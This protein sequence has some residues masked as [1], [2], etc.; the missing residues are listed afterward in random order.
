MRAAII[1]A[2]RKVAQS[3]GVVEMTLT[4]VAREASVAATDIYAFFTSK[5]DLLQAVVADDLATLA[6]TMRRN[7]ESSPNPADS[8][9]DPNDTQVQPLATESIGAADEPAIQKNQP[10]DTQVPSMKAAET[11]HNDHPDMPEMAARPSVQNAPETGAPTPVQ[12]MPRRFPVVQARRDASRSVAADANSNT[13]TAEA[14]ARLEEAV[15]KLQATPVDQWLERRLREFERTLYGLQHNQNQRASGHGFEHALQSLRESL[16]AV[17]MRHVMAGDESARTTS[18]RFD[19]FDKRLR[20]MLSELQ[21]ESVHL[22]KRITALENLAFATQLEHVPPVEAFAPV[23]PPEPAVEPAH[24]A[25]ETLHD[26]AP[27]S[28]APDRNEAPP[29]FLSA[30]RRSAA[31]AAAQQANED[32]RQRPPAPKTNRTMLYATC[33]L[34]ALF[35]VLLFGLNFMFRDASMGAPVARA[36]SRPAPARVVRTVAAARPVQHVA[37]KAPQTNLLKLA[38]TGDTSAELLVGLEYLEGK[39]KPKDEP[40]AVDWLSRAAA[41]GQPVA[42]YDL[43][44]LYADGRGVHADP[45]QAFQW[46]GSA[47]LRGNRRA[48]HF[49]AIAYA[50]GVGTTKD[51]PEAARWFERAA[52]LG[53]VNSQFNLAVLYERGMGVPQSLTTAYKWYAI[54]A[55][56]G[57]HESQ[58]RVAA[59]A[60]TLKPDDLA[61]AKAAADAFKAQPLD[62]AANLPPK[63]PS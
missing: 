49:L 12:E 2:A 4:A 39:G 44:A 38:E 26:V 27:D 5:N 9:P 6:K 62:P 43:G 14:I 57:D 45:V 55:Q 1:E 7:F 35:V 58:A 60:S 34:L 37:Q 3:E 24:E 46:F 32:L 16:E 36:A 15:A 47:A 25:I 50:E 48:M 40:M 33:G 51:L 22:A 52:N 18:D 19:A 29:S 53:A 28:T 61:S 30:A 63:L 54:A 17:D 42:Q 56:Q 20:E 13:A 41:K 21:A 31:E 11:L 59:L 23:E 8:R 10:Q